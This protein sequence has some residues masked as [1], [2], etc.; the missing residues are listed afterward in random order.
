MATVSQT[1]REGD[2]PYRTHTVFNQVPPLQGIDVFASNLPLVEATEREGAGWVR[3]RASQL[4]RFAGG[5]GD[6]GGGRRAGG[7][8]ARRGGGVSWGASPSSSGAAW[9]TRTSLCCMPST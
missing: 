2:S 1:P 3:E 8:G 6:R 9:P 5:R 7:A 4:G